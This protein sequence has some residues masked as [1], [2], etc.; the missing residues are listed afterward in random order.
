[1]ARGIDDVIT[2][3]EQE[4]G[5]YELLKG[6]PYEVLKEFSVVRC[7]KGEFRLNQGQVYDSLYI[8]VSGL[9]RIYVMT[10]SGRKYTLAIYKQ[11][12]YIGEHEI[13]D[14]RPYS[15]FV[16]A[17][18]DV[19]LLRLKR[20]PFIRW[21]G[22]DRQISDSFTRSLCHQIYML[23]EKAGTDTLYSL[24]QRICQYLVAAAARDRRVALD[25]EELG[26]LMGV[27]TRSVN[28]ILKSLREEGLIVAEGH[29]IVIRDWPA[30]QDESE[31]RVYD[32]YERK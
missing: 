7:R 15:C 25:R 28:R 10:E 23:S 16:E 27:A 11:G 2:I 32:F 26:E 17:I 3:I 6:C 4:R 24:R 18:S 20:E 22:Q 29:D 8:V 31:K 5:I 21:L 19:V 9:V 30:L 13:F 1:M 12:N 14:Q